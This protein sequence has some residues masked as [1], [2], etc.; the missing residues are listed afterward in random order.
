MLVEGNLIYRTMGSCFYQHYGRENIV[1]NNVFVC[2]NGGEGCVHLAR[3]EEHNAFSLSNNILISDGRM[4]YYI[5]G[6]DVRDPNYRSD[7]NLFCSVSGVQPEWTAVNIAFNGQGV[8]IKRALTRE[9]W[10]QLGYDMHSI[11]A[12]PGFADIANGNWT[13]ANEEVLKQIGF[14]M[15]SWDQAGIEE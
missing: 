15:P 14:R 2:A 12:D 7:V 6:A 1:R 5:G 8:E 3:V 11:E 4:P 10:M 13:G 9:A